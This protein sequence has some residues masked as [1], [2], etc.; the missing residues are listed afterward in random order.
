M[1]GSS[2]SLRSVALLRGINVGTAKAVSMAD[3]ADVFESLGATGVK[4]VLRSGNV[5]FEGSLD[6]MAIE[7]AVF[8]AT[9]V[10]S[11]VIVID[12]HS[13]RRI[14]DADPL[15]D[16]ATN[17]SRSF[18]TFLSEPH[19]ALE[20][21]TPQSLHPERLAVGDDAIYQ[22]FPD[23]SQQTKVPKSFWKQFSGHVTARNRN[24]VDTL[25]DLLEN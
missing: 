24:T 13:F 19:G 11:S 25:L 22:W 1:A 3:L 18:V 16:T 6:P 10:R 20:L 15:L 5:V 21:P 23:G 8:D 9:A 14:A 7:H 2:Q 12:A 4:T 17:G